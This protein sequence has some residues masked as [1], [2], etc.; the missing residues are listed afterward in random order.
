MACAD[1]LDEAESDIFL[2]SWPHKIWND[3]VLDFVEITEDS[4]SPHAWLDLKRAKESLLYKFNGDAT[5]GPLFH[6][7][8]KTENEEL[9][10]YR[11][12]PVVWHP[13]FCGIG[14]ER[15]LVLFV[16]ISSK[17]FSPTRRDDLSMKSYAH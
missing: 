12:N 2:Y 16:N 9:S 8:R 11:Q 4:T 5:L 10:T 1:V 17:P 15:D 14:Y 7:T 6:Q 13:H 3:A